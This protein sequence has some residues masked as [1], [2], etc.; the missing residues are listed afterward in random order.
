MQTK[1][2]NYPLLAADKDWEL[3]TFG[4]RQRLGTIHFWQQTKTGNYPLLAAWIQAQCEKDDQCCDDV[5]GYPGSLSS[6]TA[7]NNSE[8]QGT[9][10]ADSGKQYNK[11]VLAITELRAD[12]KKIAQK[13]EKEKIEHKKKTYA[14]ATYSTN[15]VK[16]DFNQQAVYMKSKNGISVT[17]ENNVD[18]INAL[19]TVPTVAMKTVSDNAIKLVFP[20][21]EAKNRGI[22]A[23]EQTE[24]Y[25]N[26][27]LSYER[28]LSG[29]LRTSMEEPPLIDY[30]LPH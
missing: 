5:I 16:S 20:N 7:D 24:D 1:T 21:N 15:H 9:G 18:I 26:Y 10:E 8:R 23:L 13:V 22:G 4:S 17:E 6:E 29:I 19:K 12:V 25:D 2:G 30:T 14:E 3:S 28:K 27:E 11:L